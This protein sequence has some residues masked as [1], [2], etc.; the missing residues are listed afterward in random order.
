MIITSKS[1]ASSRLNSSTPKTCDPFAEAACRDAFRDRD[2][3]LAREP[4]FVDHPP[5]PPRQQPRRLG[6]VVNQV[7]AETG[8]KAVNH[9]LDAATRAETKQERAAAL[10]IAENIA[11]SLGLTLEHFLFKQV[12]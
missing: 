7:V 9:W 5:L 10:E 6:E 4:E 2:I 12:A 3:R 8:E 1:P 11:K